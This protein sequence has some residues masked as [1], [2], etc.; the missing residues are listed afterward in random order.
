MHHPNDDLSPLRTAL[1]TRE[2]M[3]F[4]GVYDVFSA[5][6]AGRYYDGIFISGFSFAASH[7]GL[8][9]IGF[10]AWSDIVSFVQRVKTILPQH[11]LLVDIDDGYV[12]AEVACH[13]VALLE[14]IGVAGVIIEDQK[15]PRRCG[16]FEGKL[17]MELDDFLEKLTKVLATRRNLFVI[18]RTDASELDEILRRAKAFETAGADAI[19]A[20]GVKDLAVIHALKSEISIPLVFNQIAGGKSPAYNLS[21]LKTAGVS[22]VNYST[23]CLFAAQAALEKQMQWLTEHDGLLSSESIT[24]KDCNQLLDRNLLDRYSSE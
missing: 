18:A 6:I 2:I 22:I 21:Q 14:S 11:L 23:P 9:D 12:D 8:P 19:L 13:V 5:A 16:H 7:Y 10:I 3:P 24:F 17:L 1:K 20:D 15:R 4:I